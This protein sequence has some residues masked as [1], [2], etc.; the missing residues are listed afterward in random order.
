MPRKIAIGVFAVVAAFSVLLAASVAVV[1]ATL[2]IERIA[3]PAAHA[4]AAFGELILGA[5]VLL[6]AVYISTRVVV[7]SLATEVG[8]TG[9]R[10]LTPP[11]Q[12]P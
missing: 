2:R 5:A 12:K 11:K 8:T 6:V 9:R 3:A 4:V 10:D 1:F 7:R